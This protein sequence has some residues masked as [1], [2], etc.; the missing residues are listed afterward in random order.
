M[1]AASSLP[2]T[3][4]LGIPWHPATSGL[5][6]QLYLED[7]VMVISSIFCRNV[8]TF[9]QVWLT[10]G[11]LSILAE[12]EDGNLKITVF[13]LKGQ[14]LF[15][16]FM[17]LGSQP[18]FFR[19]CRPC[20]GQRSLPQTWIPLLYEECFMF[21]A[22]F[23]TPCGCNG[24]CILVG[25]IAGWETRKTEGVAMFTRR[26]TNDNPMKYIYIYIYIGYIQKYP[27]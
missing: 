17:K 19:K 13:V 16:T 18:L 6:F 5:V 23:S 4:S 26:E 14:E 2:N 9:D 3:D 25:K 11:F 10:S 20:L 24:G 15:Q 27:K 7:P 12:N 1:T 21:W 8:S 22:P